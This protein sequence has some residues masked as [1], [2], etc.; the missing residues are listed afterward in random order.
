MRVIGWL[1]NENSAVRSFDKVVGAHICHDLGA[2][3]NLGVELI[4]ELSNFLETLIRMM[5]IT[6]GWRNIH[7]YFLRPPLCATFALPRPRNDRRGWVANVQVRCAVYDTCNDNKSTRVVIY[8]PQTMR[9]VSAVYTVLGARAERVRV[10]HK[11][12]FGSRQGR[13]QR[14]GRIQTS[15]GSEGHS[16]RVSDDDGQAH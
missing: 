10:L 4:F 3:Q 5:T 7:Y 2:R 11:R 13:G 6:V 15:N 9:Q 12:M 8:L 14:S 1:G 16:H